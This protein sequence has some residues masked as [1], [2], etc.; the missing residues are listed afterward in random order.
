M[1][2]T[3]HELRE[4]CIMGLKDYLYQEQTGRNVSMFNNILR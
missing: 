4:I 1:F 2:H 3:A